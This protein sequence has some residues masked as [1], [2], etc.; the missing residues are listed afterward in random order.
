MLQ[1]LP[2]EKKKTN[3]CFA[4]QINWLNLHSCHG[5]ILLLFFFPF[6]F[7]F[8]KSIFEFMALVLN[9]LEYQL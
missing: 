3:G 2:S 1:N 4:I 5:D 8:V 6:L 7:F 9:L